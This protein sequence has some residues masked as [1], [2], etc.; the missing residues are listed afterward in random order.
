MLSSVL[1]TARA[2]V[3]SVNIMRAFVTMRNF[4][5]SKMLE[6]NYYQ[7]MLIRHDKEINVLQD[8]FSKFE[9][10][11][12]ANEIYFKGQ[13]Y[14]A[15]SKILDIMKK[16]KNEIVVIDSFLDKSILDMIRNIKVKV[17]CLLLVLQ[18]IALAPIKQ[19][20]IIVEYVFG[21]IH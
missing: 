7:E 18:I 16:A 21:V 2:S 19:D 12:K 10:K 11:R 15:Y 13:I 17:T 3:I 8:A 9:K 14:D 4:I 5:S 6:E 20:I 1:K